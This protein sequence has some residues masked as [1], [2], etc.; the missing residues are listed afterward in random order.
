MSDSSPAKYP[1][2]EFVALS[3][4][5]LFLVALLEWF[6]TPVLVLLSEVADFVSCLGFGP[7]FLVCEGFGF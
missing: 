6:D 4:V 7:F 1:A 2:L 3:R 5:E